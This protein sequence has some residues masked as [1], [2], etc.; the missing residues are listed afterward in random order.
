MDN[1]IIIIALLLFAS[2]NSQKVITESKTVRDSVVIREVEKD[3]LIPAFEAQSNSINID[4]L[5]KLLKSGVSRE[6]IQRTLIKEDPET[7]A[8]VGILIDELGNLTAYCGKQEEMIKFLLQE[9]DTYRF[10]VERIVVEQR[11]NIL[12]QIWKYVRNTLILLGL[13]IVGIVAFK[14]LK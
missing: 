7:K 6:T 10:E 14:L 8:R 2:C 13:A 11:E 1:R 9:K 12:K 5:Q 4:S 3:V